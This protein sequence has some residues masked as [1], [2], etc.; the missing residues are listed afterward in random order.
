MV[1]VVVVSLALILTMVAAPPKALADSTI[2]WYVTPVFPTTARG[3]G[4][5]TLK[6]A[7]LSDATWSYPFK[8]PVAQRTSQK[9]LGPH[10]ALV[11]MEVSLQ[12]DP[13]TVKS[14]GCYLTFFLNDVGI[15]DG[16]GSGKYV[17]GSP[18]NFLVALRWIGRPRT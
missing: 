18:Q 14:I 9:D 3:A 4:K 13:T 10:G 17:P 15:L 6:C 11:P 2:T 16:I 12:V 1:R 7:A 5:L 8:H